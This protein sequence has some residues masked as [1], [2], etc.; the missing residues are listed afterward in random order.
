M[1]LG[2][3]QDGVTYYAT[4]LDAVGD[5]WDTTAPGYEAPALPN[6]AVPFEVKEY[7]GDGGA[8][9]TDTI[10]SPPS[11]RTTPSQGAPSPGA[12]TASETA[13]MVT[14]NL[15]L[16][17]GTHSVQALGGS[18]GITKKWYLAFKHL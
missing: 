12:S 4:V 10:G 11:G 13:D 9:S 5:E 7:L 3:L 16:T 8:S 1:P 2:S 18:A 15:A 6:P 14:G 17:V